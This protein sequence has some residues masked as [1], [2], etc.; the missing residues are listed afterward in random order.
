MLEM[1]CAFNVQAM[2]THL[3]DGTNE[4]GCMLHACEKDG[5]GNRN[6]VRRE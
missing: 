3:K 2:N 1:V 6:D 4:E 5:R